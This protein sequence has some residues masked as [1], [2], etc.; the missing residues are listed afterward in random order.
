MSS[1]LLVQA[2]SKWMDIKE[3]ESFYLLIKWKSSLHIKDYG[4]LR[5]IAHRRL[6][7]C[8]PSLASR[9][10]CRGPVSPFY[11]RTYL[12][13]LWRPSPGVS[14][15]DR[16]TCKTP[17]PTEE[18]LVVWRVAPDGQGNLWFTGVPS[19]MRAQ[20]FFRFSGSLLPALNACYNQTHDSTERLAAFLPNH[21]LF[22]KNLP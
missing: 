17:G 12:E 13:P 3:G 11:S 21:S 5:Y 22:S 15:R 9:G 18:R 1:P 7:D 14:A 20:W 2:H 4:T 6:R 10:V 16:E 19:T 8:P